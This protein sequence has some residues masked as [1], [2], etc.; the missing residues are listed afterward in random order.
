MNINLYDLL[1]EENL[2]KEERDKLK[3]SDFGIPSIRGYPIHDETHVRAAIK[4]FS[5]AESI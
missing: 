3:D 2:K 4:L 5:K 1:I